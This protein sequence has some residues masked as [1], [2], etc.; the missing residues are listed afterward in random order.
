MS[1][2]STTPLGVTRQRS[3]VRDHLSYVALHVLLV[4]SAIAVVVAQGYFEQRYLIAHGYGVI[5]SPATIAVYSA[6]LMLIDAWL[7]K[8]TLYAGRKEKALALV[9]PALFLF[10]GIFMIW[11]SQDVELIRGS[12]PDL[13]KLL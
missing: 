11:S 8:S 4:C 5:I 2:A 13:F 12:M 1:E 10:M 3:K 9:V 7:V 6:F